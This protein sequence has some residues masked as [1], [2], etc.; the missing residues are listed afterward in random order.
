MTQGQQSQRPPRIR[1][2]EHVSASRVERLSGKEHIYQ[3]ESVFP[4]S[5]PIQNYLIGAVQSKTWVHLG[6]NADKLGPK[7]C[8]MTQN[9]ARRTNQI[10]FLPLPWAQE[11]PGSNLGAPTTYSFIFSE[12]FRILQRQKRT[13]VQVQSGSRWRKSLVGLAL[14]QRG[15]PRVPS[16]IRNTPPLIPELAFLGSA[17]R[18]GRASIHP[19]VDPRQ[20]QEPETKRAAW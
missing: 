7:P 1:A 16:S 9:K 19:R 14:S 2:H 17:Q 3:N 11:A 12:L 10:A 4:E 15:S 6:P 13:W 20:D 5:V 18:R 8:P